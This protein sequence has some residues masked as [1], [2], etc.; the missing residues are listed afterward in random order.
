MVDLQK[1]NNKRSLSAQQECFI[2]CCSGAKPTGE[3][4]SLNTVRQETSLKIFIHTVCHFLVDK[5]LCR[6]QSLSVLNWCVCSNTLTISA[7]P[8]HLLLRVLYSASL[9]LS[10][11]KFTGGHSPQPT[12]FCLNSSSSSDTNGMHNTSIFR[13]YTHNHPLPHLPIK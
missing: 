6:G 13:W 1:R 5:S 3:S 2:P 7:Q 8:L 4:F 11:P 9:V 10:P 12:R